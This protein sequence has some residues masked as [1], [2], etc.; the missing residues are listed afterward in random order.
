MNFT[1]IAIA[2]L[3]A[4]FVSAVYAAEKDVPNPPLPN[5][6]SEIMFLYAARYGCLAAVRELIQQQAVR[7]NRIEQA[8]IVAVFNGRLEIVQYLVEVANVLASVDGGQALFYAA[9][10]GNYDVVNYFIGPES[11]LEFSQEECI[12]AIAGAKTDEIRDLIE[13]Y[14]ERTEFCPK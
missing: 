2:T 12:K 5:P 14:R 10:R 7:A 6:R 1:V 4:L 11:K 9:S 8:L 3:L 13:N